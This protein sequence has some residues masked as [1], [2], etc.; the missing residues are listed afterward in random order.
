[1]FRKKIVFS[2]KVILL[3]SFFFLLIFKNQVFALRDNEF[4]ERIIRKTE[5]IHVALP[6][7]A[8]NND[9]LSYIQKYINPNFNGF[10]SNSPS[11]NSTQ[12]GSIHWYIKDSDDDLIAVYFDGGTRNERDKNYDF[13]DLRWL[14]N[15]SSHIYC[16]WRMP[17]VDFLQH[18]DILKAKHAKNNDNLGFYLIWKLPGLKKLPPKKF[19]KNSP[20]SN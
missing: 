16:F 8:N 9:V 17:E 4:S 18:H 14:G 6:Q 7:N 15:G 11:Y 10:V 13:V 5:I 20:K 3:L 1:M 19:L 12:Y 2:Q